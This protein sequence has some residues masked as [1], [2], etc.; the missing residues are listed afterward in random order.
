MHRARYTGL[1]PAQEAPTHEV[2]RIG[3]TT[4]WGSASGVQMTH[5]VVPRMVGE[6][7]HIGWVCGP[8]PLGCGLI[9]FTCACARIRFG[10][11]I[12]WW[13]LYQDVI[14]HGMYQDV[15]YHGTNSLETWHHSIGGL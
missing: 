6:V 9:H 8:A 4:V 2:L 11:D 10:V 13:C 15:I 7:S 1:N 12:N 5:L 14:Y 3:G